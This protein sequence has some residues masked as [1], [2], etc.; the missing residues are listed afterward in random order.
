MLYMTH[1]EISLYPRCKLIHKLIREM[2]LDLPDQVSHF[3]WSSEFYRC[4]LW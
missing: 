2:F 1:Q 4:R 3:G